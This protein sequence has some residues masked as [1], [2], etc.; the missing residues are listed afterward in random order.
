MRGLRESSGVG[1]LYSQDL[2]VRRPMGWRWFSPACLPGECGHEDSM[3]PV[4]SK[5]EIGSGLKV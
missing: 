2:E 3:A 4:L 5:G 1:H